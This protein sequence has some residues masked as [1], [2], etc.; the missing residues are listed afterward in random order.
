MTSMPPGWYDDGHGALRWWDGARWTEHVATPDPEPAAAASEQI[1]DQPT[2]VLPPELAELQQDADTVPYADGSVQPPEGAYPGGYPGGFPGG[3]APAGAF[4]SATEPKKSKLW[5]VWVVLGVVLL[6]IVIAAAVLIPLLFLTANAGGGSGGSADADEA[7]AIAAVELYDQAW[8]EVDCDKFITA[9]T[10][11]FRAMIGL[12]DC[13]AFEPE[14]TA[15]SE[16]VENYVVTVTDVEREGDTITVSTTETFGSFFDDD[17]NPV[18]E[19][20]PVE[21]DYEY[22]L[23]PAGD[24]WAIDDAD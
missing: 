3:T 12:E 2:D 15:F 23:V 16:S 17:G 6:G 11:D 21:E 7:A 19:S 24:G 10:E 13:A 14:A 18:D 4:V 9:T 22:V 20:I 5:I 8:S 1:A